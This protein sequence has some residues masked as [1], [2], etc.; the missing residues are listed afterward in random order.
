MGRWDRTSPW[1][2]GGDVA[3]AAAAIPPWRNGAL[4]SSSWIGTLTSEYAAACTS[5]RL[6]EV[7]TLQRHVIGEL[8][9]DDARHHP[10]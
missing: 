5:D 3:S 8:E 6:S 2:G 9:D 7:Q 1:W 10:G 4:G